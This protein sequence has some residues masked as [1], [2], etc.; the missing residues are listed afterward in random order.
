MKN[1]SNKKDTV[2]SVLLRIEKELKTI[3]SG[4]GIIVS[5][6][7]LVKSIEETKPVA[8]LEPKANEILVDFP[9]KTMKEIYKETGNKAGNGK[10]LYS[11]DWYQ[12][13]DFFT[14][15][16]C[17]AG[18]R[19]VSL[20]LKHL[21]KSWDEIVAMGMQEEMLSSAEVTYLLAYVPEYREVLKNWKYT[22][23]S[24]HDS[25]G[26]LVRVGEFDGEGASVRRYTP[27]DRDDDIGVL[28]TKKV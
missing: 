22:W 28:L 16:K 26:H 12:N 4:V 3:R 15:D 25:G 5:S 24:R 21:G 6:N 13:E 1:T 23:T 19:I 17:R 18:K 9:A 2:L 11:I 8:S 27:D 20:D 7:S 10:L 14:K